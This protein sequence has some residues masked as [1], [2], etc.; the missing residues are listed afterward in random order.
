MLYLALLGLYAARGYNQ[1]LADD[2][3]YLA[4]VELVLE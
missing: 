4:L 2:S 1:H 3:A